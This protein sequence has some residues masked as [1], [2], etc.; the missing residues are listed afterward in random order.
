MS[1][2]K[3]RKKKAIK[4]A[5]KAATKTATKIAM[6]ASLD[7]CHA[8]IGQLASAVEE[9]S[10]TIETLRQEKERIQA[11]FALLVQRMF[12]RRSERY[13]NDP[14]QLKLDLGDD[15]NAADAAEGLAQAVEE[16][17]I[18]VKGHVRRPRKPRN[19]SL[20]ENLERYEVVV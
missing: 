20:P 12:A 4:P 14:N 7:A 17:G 3:K 16:A 10:S 2:S 1:H 11:E 6:P 19:E 15:D 8:L 13:L 5:A 9:Q 18:P